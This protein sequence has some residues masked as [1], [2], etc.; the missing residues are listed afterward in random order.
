ML[1]S[2]LLVGH[3]CE[4]SLSGRLELHLLSLKCVRRLLLTKNRLLKWLSNHCLTRFGK[5]SSLLSALR[6]EELTLTCSCL[7]TKQWF[8]WLCFLSLLSKQAWLGRCWLTCWRRLC[9]SWIS[10]LSEKIACW[11]SCLTEQTCCTCLRVLSP[12]GQCG[13]SLWRGL[14]LLL[15]LKSC[16]ASSSEQVRCFLGL[17]WLSE[18]SLLLHL[19]RLIKWL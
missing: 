19:C 14:L 9:L 11:S 17:I 15:S 12:K 2:D 10:G 3:K 5:Q 18:H 1:V 4:T 13:C 16:S 6:S 7:V 8:V